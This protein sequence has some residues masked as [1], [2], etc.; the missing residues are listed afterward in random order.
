MDRRHLAVHLFGR[1]AQQILAVLF[2][3][4]FPQPKQIGFE[5]RRD[6]GQLVLMSGNFASFNE[7]L[8]IERDTDGMPC[9]RCSRNRFDVERLDRPNVCTLVRRRKHEVVADLQSPRCDASGENTAGIELIDILHR[10][11]QWL[12][13]PRRLLLKEAE[14]IQYGRAL[15]PG[16]GLT[17]VR[18]IVAKFGADRNDLFRHRSELSQKLPILLLDSLEHILAIA[19]EIHLVDRDGELAYTQER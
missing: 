15:V 8:F 10:E 7:N 6:E 13:R 9:F 5:S 18:N 14:Y 12:L 3:R 17:S 19:D 1:D 2:Q 11:P 16:H 4:T